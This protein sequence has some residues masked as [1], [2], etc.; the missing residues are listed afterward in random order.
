MTTF[1]A[2]AV[3]ADMAQRALRALAHAIRSVD[4]LAVHRGLW[5]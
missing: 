5:L 3:D 1:E 2:S 4:P